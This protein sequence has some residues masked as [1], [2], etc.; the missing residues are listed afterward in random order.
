MKDVFNFPN[1]ASP[2][3]RAHP[4]VMMGLLRKPLKLALVQLA[5][6]M[7]YPLL[8]INRDVCSDRLK[9]QIS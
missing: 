6:G 3:F 2:G 9:A 5:I 4:S 7:F 1:S 8:M